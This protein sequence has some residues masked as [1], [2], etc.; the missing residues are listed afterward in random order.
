MRPAL[1]GD[2]DAELIRLAAEVKAAYDAWGHAIARGADLLE[3]RR[4]R[5]AF[6]R[7]CGYTDAEAG[8]VGACEKFHSVVDA[9]CKTHAT[10]L[11]GLIAKARA[12]LM[13]EGAMFDGLRQSIVADI[14]ALDA[15][16]VRA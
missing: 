1:A 14:L 16:A 7:A 9:M 3:W 11:R 13:D 8:E 15:G 4:R 6:Q 2:D 10:S 5:A 12:T